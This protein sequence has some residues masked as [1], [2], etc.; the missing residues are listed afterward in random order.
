M[1]NVAVHPITGKEMEYTALMK[2]PTLEP[3][4]KLGL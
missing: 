4:W 3:L 1:A 2:Y